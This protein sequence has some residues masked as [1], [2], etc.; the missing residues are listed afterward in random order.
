VTLEHYSQRQE[1]QLIPPTHF[2]KLDKH[3]VMVV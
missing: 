1:T 2:L 3:Q